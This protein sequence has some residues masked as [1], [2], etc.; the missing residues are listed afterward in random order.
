MESV[1]EK[2]ILGRVLIDP[3]VRHKMECGIVDSKDTDA[4]VNLSIVHGHRSAQYH[5]VQ[6]SKSLLIKGFGYV[7][8]LRVRRT[9][10]C[11]WNERHAQ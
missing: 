6:Q 2:V 9:G 3:F 7:L 10:P 8:G 1:A 11:V 5:R 4:F